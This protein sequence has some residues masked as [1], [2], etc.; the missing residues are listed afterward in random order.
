MLIENAANPGRAN[1]TAFTDPA[2]GKAFSQALNAGEF[3]G[4]DIVSASIGG[5]AGSE[6]GFDWLG[7]PYDST[8]AALSA[9]G[10][11]TLSGSQTVTIEPGTGLA[12]LS[13]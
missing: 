3:A 5:G 9:A 8:E 1:A 4:V 13:P 2:T 12:R 6:V 10:T 7:S 11:I